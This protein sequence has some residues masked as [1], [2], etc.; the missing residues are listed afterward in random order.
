MAAAR[1][2]A[3][4]LLPQL[5]AA[6]A[7]EENP[8]RG[9]PEKGWMEEEVPGASQLRHQ[10]PTMVWAEL[11]HAGPAAGRDKA[12]S[13]PRT[14]GSCSLHLTSLWSPSMKSSGWE[15]LEPGTARSAQLSSREKTLNSAP[16]CGF[17]KHPPGTDPQHPKAPSRSSGTQGK[18]ELHAGA[19]HPLKAFYFIHLS[20]SFQASHQYLGKPKLERDSG[21]IFESL[22]SITLLKNLCP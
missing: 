5:L 7:R 14:P 8:A 4:L 17:S 10:L 3:S 12:V 1:G 13:P 21:F 6:T 19:L 20:L 2:E 11:L 22:T 15:A 16:Q 9:C 18:Q